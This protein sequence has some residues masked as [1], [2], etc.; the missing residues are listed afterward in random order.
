MLKS[1]R[2]VRSDFSKIHW[3]NRPV[4]IQYDQKVR[5]FENRRKKTCLLRMRKGEREY[6]IRKADNI[7]SAF[8]D[9]GM[10]YKLNTAKQTNTV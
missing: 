1:N 6:N 4:L 7:L 8:C 2:K 5:P 9:L 3:G 10:N